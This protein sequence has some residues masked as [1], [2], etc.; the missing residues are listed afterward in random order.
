METTDYE[1]G[2][3]PDDQ[4]KGW[5]PL[6]AVWIAIGIDLSGAF[7]GIELAKGMDFW[8]AMA[9]TFIGSTILGLLAMATSYIGAVT[10]LSTALISRVTFGRIG[11]VVLSLVLSI[12]LLG[13]FSVQAGFFG[14]HGQVAIAKLLGWD[15]PVWLTTGIGGALMLLTALWGYRSIS[16][17]SE[18]AVPLMLVLL[19]LG[20]ILGFVANGAAG[21]DTPSDG[22]LPFG[23]VVSLVISI[24][25]MGV[26]VAPDFARWAKTPKQ[27]MGAG[28][29]GF[30]IGNSLIV[31]VAMILTRLVGADDLITIF[32]ILGIG[33]VAV[34]I[35][36]LAQWTTNTTNL[37][38][39]ALSF[40]TISG[41]LNRRVVTIVIGLVGIVVAMLGAAD[42][43]IAFLS[44]I[45]IIV[46]PFGGVYLATFIFGRARFALGDARRTVEPLALVAWVLGILTALSTAVPADGLGFGLFTFTTVSSLDGLIVGFVA[47]AIGALIAGKRSQHAGDPGVVAAETAAEERAEAA[48]EAS[49]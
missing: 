38:S 39:S 41:K 9:A 31:V 46:A 48:E 33:I 23:T 25:V 4:R 13:W 16:K 32:F 7:L 12:C 42:Y 45:G 29:L 1:H 10:G 14:L 35:L 8:P 2:R 49:R 21:L 17:L 40:S 37:Y 18:W 22:S 28:F 15:L 24:F 30:F 43:F 20:V 6:T 36:I 19:V 5:L 34:V 3:V 44:A 27:A 26:C 47:Y 11:G